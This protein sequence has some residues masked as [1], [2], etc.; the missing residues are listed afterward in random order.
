MTLSYFRVQ[1][2]VL[3]MVT[4]RYDAEEE[5]EKIYRERLDKIIE[6]CRRAKRTKKQ[7]VDFIRKCAKNF[8][9]F[10][11]DDYINEKSEELNELDRL[12][13]SN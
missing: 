2:G 6:D 3:G 13:A 11:L 12:A 10:N 8:N 7:A 4:M 5:L 9:P 1:H